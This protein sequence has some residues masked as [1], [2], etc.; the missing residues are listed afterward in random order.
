MRPLRPAAVVVTLAALAVCAAAGPPALASPL[1]RQPAGVP[2]IDISSWQPHVNWKTVTADHLKFAYIKATEG[3]Y[4]RSPDFARQRKGA[5]AAG[6]VTG[7]YHFAVPSSSGGAAQA[8]YFA[9]H[10]GGWKAGALPGVLDIETNPYGRRACYGLSHAAM[11]GW[12]RAFVRTYHA[13]TG[14]WPVINTFTRWWNR[15]T[16]HST[17]FAAKDALWIN[18]HRAAAAPL[19]AG[20]TSYTVWQWAQSGTYPADQDVIPARLFS[21]LQHEP[22]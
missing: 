4:Y 19:P 18:A 22:H 5:R 10:G 14:W 6:V 17:A 13:R 8:R 11:T 16:G 15:C 21:K 20:W 2:G 3:T 1:A 9:A 12:I 7:A